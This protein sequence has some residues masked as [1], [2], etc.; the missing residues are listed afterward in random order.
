MKLAT[1]LLFLLA[2]VFSCET[3]EFEATVMKHYTSYAGEESFV[4]WR[5]AATTGTQVLSVSGTSSVSS[6]D[7]TYTFCSTSGLHTIELIDSYGDGWGSSTAAAYLVISISGLEIFRGGLPYQSGRTLLKDVKTFNPYLEISLGSSWKYSDVSQSGTGWAATT[8]SDASWSSANSGSMPAFTATTRYYRLQ[9]TLASRDVFSALMLTL[10]TGEGAAVYVQGTEVYRYKLPSGTLTGSSVANSATDATIV[11]KRISFNKFLLPTSGTYVIAIEIHQASGVTAGA[12]IFDVGGAYFGSAESGECSNTR[13][14]DGT[15]TSTPDGSSTSYGAS[16]VVDNSISTYFYSST[17]GS[18]TFVYTLPAGTSEWVNTY[19]LTSST[20]S[21]YGYPKTW[22]FYG[23]TDGNTWTILDAKEN[24]IFSTTQVTVNFPIRSNDKSF[25]QYKLEITAGTISGK[26]SLGLMQVFVCNYAYLAPG[27]QYD[28]STITGYAGIDTIS[29]SPASNGYTGFTVSPAFPDG[30]TLSATTGSISGTPTSASSGTYTISASYNGQSYTFAMTITITACSAPTHTNLRFRKV[31]KSW[32]TEESWTMKNAAGSVVY[33]SPVLT[34]S[35]DQTFIMCIASGVYT[36]TVADSY[37]DG[38]TSGSRLF[39]ELYDYEGSYYPIASL[40]EHKTTNNDYTFDFAYA[41]APKASNWQYVQGSVPAAWYGTATP[42]GFS[43]FSMDPLPATTSTIWL[44]RNVVSVVTKTGYVGF[45]IRVKARAGFVVYMNGVELYRT[46]LSAGDITTATAATGG[47]ST[48]TFHY[49]SGDNTHI[50]VGSNVLAIGIVNLAGNNPTT[51]LFDAS[52]QLFK[53][54]ALGRNWD[55]TASDEPSGSGVS[56]LIDLLPTTTWYV[57]PAAL[58]PATVLLNYG[59][60]RAEQINKYCFT[61][62][63]LNE[64]YDPSDWAVYGSN[65]VGITWTLLGNVTNAYF[66]GR[67]VERC[68]Y[69]PQNTKAWNEYKF[70][71]TEPALPSANPYEFALALITMS[72]EDLD[73]L[74]IPALSLSSTTFTGYIGVPFP[75]VTPSSSLWGNF[76]ITPALNLPLE[77]DT[78]TGSIRGTPITLLPSQSYTITASNPKG[79]DSSVSVTLSV[80]ACTS[81]NIMFV[82]RIHSGAAGNEQGY[83]LSDKSGAAISSKTG[84]TN[85]QDNYY[86]FC[87][88]ADVYTLK[89]TDSGGDGWDSGYFQILLEDNSLV[90]GGSLGDGESEKTFTVSVGYVIPPVHSTWKYL[91][92]G[93]AA[94]S[95]WNSL[96]FSDATWKEAMPSAFE[97]AVGTT[98]YF[99]KTFTIES[100]SSYASVVFNIKTKYGIVVYINGQEQYRYNIATGSVSYNTYASS[101][102]SE[103]TYVG[104]SMSVSFGN[105]VQGANVIAVEVHRASTTT[106]TVIDFDAN[107]LVAAEGSYRVIDGTASSSVATEDTV[108][109]AFDNIKGSVYVAQTRCVGADPTWT[110]NNDRKEYISSYSI[111]TGP[112]CNKRH[113]SAWSFQGSNDGTNW[114]TLNLVSSKKFENFG[115]EYSVDFYNNKVYNAYR[116]LAQECDNS[117]LGSSDTDE[118]CEYSAGVQG[119]QL[120]EISMYTKNINGA[121]NPDEAKGWGGALEGAYAYKNCAAYYQGRIQALCTNGVRG[122][123]ESYCTVM[124]PQRIRYSTK[125]MNVYKGVAFSY[126]PQ[127]SAAEFTCSIDATLP[128]GINF[129]T[130]TGTIS[131]TAAEIF[132]SQTYLVT[133]T[134]TAGSVETEVYI[135]STEKPGLPIYAWIIIGILAVIIVGVVV[136]C[137]INRTKSRK[138]KGHSNLDKKISSK[139]RSGSKKGGENTAAKTV[140]V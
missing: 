34:N 100:V 49:I 30:I 37:G 110:F 33:S 132:E 122:T 59:T 138:N 121:C 70:Y 16:K 24:Y 96:T 137:I 7:Q 119:F 135:S 27:L 131:G 51:V 64:A 99:R 123:E 12:D 113:P 62:S 81:P 22:N 42:T 57:S 129:D 6:T 76:R 107:L 14:F 108:S 15:I 55:L 133:C 125:M 39:V 20:V 77:I 127:V 117:N 71:F 136:L 10:K 79:Q 83:V 128:T 73:Q 106:S 44:F 86:P 11:N 72:T 60:A 115:E 63:Y 126:V 111:I 69:L 93:S 45:E 29:V 94:G 38:W 41:L 118:N 120:A 21:T 58:A 52:F 68:F 134:N 103:S 47:D 114:S 43:A 78:S 4:I 84:F 75:E 74:V 18:V 112:K 31:N 35:V 130:K 87:K 98:Q 53:T 102:K 25:S 85:D 13:F 50:Q 3:G 56:Y 104:S 97:A 32:A 19:A 116:F 91:N 140:K 23:S 105:L 101:E 82:L 80:V 124:T 90:L 1:T 48:S 66:S 88:S 26:I 40:Y 54:N 17:S 46:Y 28:V 2:I 5:G 8:Y 65:D 92:S 36:V 89:V 61:S 109:N 95:G 9:K 139:A 67:A